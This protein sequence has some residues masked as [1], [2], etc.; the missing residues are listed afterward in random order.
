MKR[1]GNDL[2]TAVMTATML[3]C[4]QACAPA[5]EGDTEREP[6]PEDPPAAMDAA[7]SAPPRPLA[8]ETPADAGAS[9]DLARVSDTRTATDVEQVADTGN[10]G[11]VAHVPEAGTGIEDAAPRGETPADGAGDHKTDAASDVSTPPPA[12]YNNTVKPIFGWDASDYDHG[13]GMRA[14]HIAAAQKEGIRFFTHKATEQ[15]AVRIWRHQNYKYAI[16]AARAAG[17]PFL[18][19]Y[20]V[21]RSGIAVSTQVATALEYV[22]AQ[23]PWWKDHPGWFW[24]ID[25]EKWPHD[26]VPAPLGEEMAAMLEKQTGKK[27]ILYASRGQYGDTLPGTTRPLWNANYNSAGSP[28]PF[29]Q[30][31]AGDSAPGWV[32]YSGRMPAILQY[33]SSAIIGGQSTCDANAFRG[34]EADFAKLI[35]AR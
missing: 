13:R 33:T 10:G 2:V 11:D 20:I 25:L 29:K 15:S 26:A 34:T 30:M 4:A 14:N 3:L 1:L 8:P 12:R 24:Q 31:Y 27:A 7:R 28:R 22:N 6:P 16:E 9:T 5:P 35:N 32:R 19:A 18:G 23:T 17:I 21:V